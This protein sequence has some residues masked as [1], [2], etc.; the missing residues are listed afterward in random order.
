M[1]EETKKKISDTLKGRKR[2]PHSAE[3]R[4]KISKAMMGKNKGR[5]LTSE[6]RQRISE[7][8]KG[9]VISEETRQKIRQH[10]DGV[11]QGHHYRK[12]GSTEAEYLFQS[13]NPQLENEVVFGTG[14]GGKRKWSCCSFVADF[15]DHHLRIIYEIDG[16]SHKGREKSDARKDSFFR[17]IGYTVIRY[18]NEEVFEMTRNKET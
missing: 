10:H 4:R 5:K 18:T 14:I 15:V 11:W 9:R 17:S 3:T 12:D 7:S 13:M 8:G 2:G 6:H 16:S 1:E